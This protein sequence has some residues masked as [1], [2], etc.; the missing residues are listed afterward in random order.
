MAAERVK[1]EIWDKAKQPIAD[2]SHLVD[3][4]SRSMT[5]KRNG[6]GRFDFSLDMDRLAD[7]AATIGLHPR[8]LIW[9][10]NTDIVVSLDGE[11]WKGFEVVATTPYLSTTGRTLSV[12]CLSFLSLL[13]SRYVTKTYTNTES[14]TIAANLITTTQGYTNGN[15]GIT[16]GAQQYV[17]GVQRIR[18]YEQ[19]KVSDALINLTRLVD[20]KF[21]FNFTYDKRFETYAYIGQLHST[22]LIYGNSG[23]VKTVEAPTEGGTLANYV[24]GLGSG[25]GK[26]QLK[27]IVGNSISQLAYGRREAIAMFSSVTEQT[28]L[29]E[30]TSGHLATYKDMLQIPRITITNDVINLSDL[31]EGD[32]FQVD[33]SADAWCES[34]V[35]IYR[36]EEIS[37]NWDDNDFAD[38]VL[39]F[40]DQGVDQDE[41]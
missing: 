5:L 27:S 41:S 18:T 20:G 17:T 14:T 29:N 3:G 16:M 38:I 31:T 2:I 6:I 26:D 12:R 24:T 28:T 8:N 37:V 4:T 34:V 1:I 32:R 7:Y 23:N 10:L 19:Q 22:P 30:N 33:L 40:D 39:N 21:D 36:A 9:P 25:F 15:F 35:G 13:S 11:P